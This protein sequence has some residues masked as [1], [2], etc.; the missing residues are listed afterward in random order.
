MKTVFIVTGVARGPVQVLL[1]GLSAMVDGLVVEMSTLN[2][3]EQRQRKF[4]EAADVAE[5]EALYQLHDLIISD[6]SDVTDASGVDPAELAAAR[7]EVGRR[8][9]EHAALAAS[10]AKELA[11]QKAADRAAGNKGRDALDAAASAPA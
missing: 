4:V 5:A 11:A 9:A 10:R 1:Q 2:G 6:D 3:R 8:K 7:G